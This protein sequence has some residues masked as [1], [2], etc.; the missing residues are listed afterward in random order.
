MKYLVFSDTHRS[1]LG[2]REVIK[3]CVGI[4]GVIF[5]GDN[6]DDSEYIAREY[7]ELSVFAVADNCDIEAKYLAPA[8]QEMILDIDGLKVLLVHGHRHEVKLG[9]G[10]LE[11]Y[12]RSRGVD[13][14]LFGHTHK[15]CDKYVDGLYI[16]NPGSTSQPRDGEA[17]FGVMTVQ[18]GQLLFSHG[19][20]WDK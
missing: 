11:K 2:V 20:V 1:L 5:L 18:K 10:I 19:S 16:F 15:R 9:L 3:R 13:A 8:Y 4:D 12:A 14:V 6:F 17:S 7:P